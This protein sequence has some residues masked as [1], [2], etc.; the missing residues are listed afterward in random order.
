VLKIGLFDASLPGAD[1]WDM[2]IR[3][4]A[5]HRVVGCP[6]V[7]VEIREHDQNQGKNAERMY[8]IAAR[9]VE[10]NSHPHAHCPQCRRAYGS[11]RRRVREDYYV[12]ACNA[13]AVALRKGK[14]REA[15]RLRLRAIWR[16]PT[17]LGRIPTRVLQ[18]VRSS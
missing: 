7:L 15:F 1:D 9:V 12:K 18:S 17:A 3:I 6:D 4:A 16:N 13:A 8:G 14:Y 5:W 2:W 10:K 11:A